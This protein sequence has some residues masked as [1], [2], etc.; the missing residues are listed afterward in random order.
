MKI[1]AYTSVVAAAFAV[2]SAGAAGAQ[3]PASPNELGM[4]GAYMGVARGY[5]SIFLAPG[6]IAAPG[7]PRWSIAF[8]QVALGAGLLGPE[9]QDL[10]DLADYDGVSATRQEEL[11]ALFPE[12][13]T[14]ARFS[15]RAPV[16][17]FTMGGLGL[18]VSYASAG[19]HTFSRDIVELML[20]GY[21]DGRTDYSV[22]DTFGER[23]TY[24]DIAGTYGRRSGA[25]SLGATG[26]LILGRT[27]VRSRLFD[28]RIYLATQDIEVDYVGVF[29]RGGWGY[30]IDLGA[31]YQATPDVTVSVALSNALSSMDWSDDL[32]VRKL[33]LDR[34]LI[35]N[36]EPLDLR[37]RYNAS[38][39]DLDPESSD[40]QVLSTLANLFDDAT[41]PAVA[42]FGVAWN[43][44]RSTTFAADYHRKLTDGRLGDE[45]DR[46]L[47]FG[48]QQSLAMFAVR[49]GYAAGSDG[50]NMVTGGL[51]AGPLDIGVA[52]YQR[53]D[54][55]G[56]RTR[57]WIGTFGLGVNQPF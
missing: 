10:F 4:G 14:E 46:R 37:N 21:E 44:A 6:N 56:E 29:A 31:A 53:S 48:V 51:S 5:E 43:P 22:G 3:V 13:G 19:R 54:F 35:D 49:A 40:S 28:P 16:L 39:G 1:F 33:T 7:A 41:F 50:G 23:A 36:A 12:R 8:P 2:I 52:R 26:H 27:I 30:A 9:L 18:G 24:W 15:L 57:G 42:R 38:E 47:S 17:A 25:V 20:D 11:L 45:W 34:D 55:E 32:K